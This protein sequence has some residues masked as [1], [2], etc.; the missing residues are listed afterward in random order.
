MSA[1]FYSTRVG[2]HNAKS[3][4]RSDVFNFGGQITRCKRTLF[5]KDRVLTLL[6][7]LLR[8]HFDQ[9]SAVVLIRIYLNIRRPIKAQT[10]VRGIL[11]G[12]PKLSLLV[13]KVV[14]LLMRFTS[15]S[16]LIVPFSR[17]KNSFF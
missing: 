2:S 13:V 17:C 12:H 11:I 8:G 5:G 9:S 3:V 4:W 15:F 6:P 1:Y 16:L 10:Y 7:H 14:S